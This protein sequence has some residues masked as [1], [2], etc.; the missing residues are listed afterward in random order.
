MHFIQLLVSAHFV[1]LFLFLIL[2][3]ILKILCYYF[4]VPFSDWSDHFEKGKLVFLFFG[5]ILPIEL[6][7]LEKNSFQ[8]TLN[9]L[10]RL[11]SLSLLL[12]L[13]SH[14]HERD[15]RIENESCRD[16]VVSEINQLQYSP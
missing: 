9:F 2:V 10:N 4:P 11:I 13:C 1:E 14:Q 3:W 6:D 15:Q 12:H 16:I 8:Q 7:K 5:K